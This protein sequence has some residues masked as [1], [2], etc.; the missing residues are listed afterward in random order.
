MTGGHL[1]VYPIYKEYRGRLGLRPGSYADYG[2][3]RGYLYNSQVTKDP[4]LKVVAWQWL[5]RTYHY[6]SWPMYQVN[7]PQH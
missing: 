7:Y 3:A 2:V 4:G 1:R 6:E 5:T